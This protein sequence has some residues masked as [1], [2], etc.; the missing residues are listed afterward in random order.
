MLIDALDT[1]KEIVQLI[2]CSPKRSHLFSEMLM[3]SDNTDTLVNI[4]PLCTTRWTARHG[5]LKAILKDY[6]ILMETMEEIHHISHDEY[7]LKAAGILALLEKFSTLFG[8]ELGYL[9]FGAAEFLSNTLQRRDISIQKAVA[10]VSLAKSFYKCQRKEEAFNYFCDKTTK[11]ANNL[12]IGL[13]SFPR[14]R[15]APR[16]LDEGSSAHQFTTPKDYFRCHYYQVCDLLL[17]ELEDRFEQSRVLPSVLALENLLITA[18]NGKDFK[19]HLENISK[20]C[21]KDDFNFNNLK[22]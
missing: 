21:Y 11:S 4:K 12:K 2:K 9:V 1:V 16:R 8:L 17:R 6:S 3:Q 18:A 20:S 22:N 7:G 19:E 15:R 13:P 5:A 14:N 10:A